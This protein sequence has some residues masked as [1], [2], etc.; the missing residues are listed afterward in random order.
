MPGE[1]CGESRARMVDFIFPW[2][3]IPPVDLHTLASVALKLER[4]G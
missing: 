3:T 2:C 1:V 4:R